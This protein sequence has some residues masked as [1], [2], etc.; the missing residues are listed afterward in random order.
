MNWI[1]NEVSLEQHPEKNQKMFYS[2]S[3]NFHPMLIHYLY[4]NGIKG[5]EGINKFFYPSY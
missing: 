4:S 5:F 1:T 2:R 3:F